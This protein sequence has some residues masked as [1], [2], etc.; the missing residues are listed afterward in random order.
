MINIT[1]A[2][3][4]SIVIFFTLTDFQS[5]GGLVARSILVTP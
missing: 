2:I 5:G 3:F 1:N 4:L